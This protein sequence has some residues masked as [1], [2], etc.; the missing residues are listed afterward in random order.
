MSHELTIIPAFEKDISL[1]RSLAQQIWPQTYSSILSQAQI[2]YM[3]DMMYSEQ[4][5]R[6][7]MQTD[8]R[9]II[10]YRNNAAVGFAAY[11]EIE[12]AIYKLFKI[13]VLWSEQRKGTGKFIIEH[14]INNIKLK[15]A[16]ALQLN[17]NR[18]NKAKSF[19]DKLGFAVIKTEDIDIGGGFFM[20]DYIMERDLNAVP[21]Q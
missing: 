3:M 14:V 11:G 2:S 15:G 19:Y 5:I 12:P 10:A 6:K 18:Y 4:A 8:H 13:Y 17:V 7:Q 1:I 20:N 21:V 9:F 16:T